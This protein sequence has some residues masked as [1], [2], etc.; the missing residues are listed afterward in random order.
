MA[1]QNEAFS[2]SPLFPGAMLAL[3]LQVSLN[4]INIAVGRRGTAEIGSYNNIS[5]H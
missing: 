1:G 5:K 3:C 4:T 2:F